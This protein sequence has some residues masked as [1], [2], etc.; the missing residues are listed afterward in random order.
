MKC[1]L[2]TMDFSLSAERKLWGKKK[3]IGA[4][5][6]LVLNSFFLRTNFKN[7]IIQISRTSDN[8]WLKSVLWESNLIFQLALLNGPFFLILSVWV[9]I[10]DRSFN[11]M[12]ELG[13][14]FQ[15]WSHPFPA[16]VD[17]V[18]T[19]KCMPD[20]GNCQTALNNC[21]GFAWSTAVDNREVIVFE[22]YSHYCKT[23]DSLLFV[24]LIF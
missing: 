13:L 18:S 22:G 7:I 16:N 11:W 17:W 1:Y 4:F 20:Q 23:V 10:S 24:F 8:S 12:S 14:R 15:R 19:N 3:L 2:V 5:K 21:W 6:I 9:V